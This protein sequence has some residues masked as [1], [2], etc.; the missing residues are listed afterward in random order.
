MI[1]LM[2]YLIDDTQGGYTV[3]H[4]TVSNGHYD[5]A[6]LLIQS[7]ADVYIQDIVSTHDFRT[8]Y[9]HDHS[10]DVYYC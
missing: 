7:G 4:W 3:L 10:H 8:V 1:I 5:C 6:E 9:H 2:I